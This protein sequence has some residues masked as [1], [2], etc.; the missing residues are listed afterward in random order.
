MTKFSRRESGYD[1]PQGKPSR[2]ECLVALPQTHIAP[3]MSAGRE[4]V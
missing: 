1:I 4:G 2:E 3:T